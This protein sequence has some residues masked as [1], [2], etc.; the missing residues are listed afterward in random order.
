MPRLVIDSAS[1]NPS[2]YPNA[3]CYEVDLPTTLT[4]VTTM[5]L[6]KSDV[7]FSDTLIGL[8][9]DRVVLDSADG[10]REIELSHGDYDGAASLAATLQA[11]LDSQ[12][13]SAMITVSVSG[14]SLQLKSTAPFTVSD[15]DTVLTDVVGRPLPTSVANTA[16]RVLGL[17]TRTVVRSE[18]DGSAY[19]VTFPYPVSLV[20]E[21]YLVLKMG[22][23]E[24]VYSSAEHVDGALGILDPGL[25]AIKEPCTV[26]LNPRRTLRKL[27]FTITRP[28]G[29]RYNFR[30]RDHRLEIQ[31]TCA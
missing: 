11:A 13:P 1:R 25:H 15:S 8:G 9:Q 18:W 3:D 29:S 28:N 10:V 26:H 4:D 6:L 24:G 17:A 7:P 19:A 16:A 23:G 22:G 21:R 2:L 31:V 12:Y 30:G 5:T 27:R 14:D 20:N